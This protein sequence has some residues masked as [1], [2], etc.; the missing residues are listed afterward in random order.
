[1]SEDGGE[2]NEEEDGPDEAVETIGGGRPPAA[3]CWS[4]IKIFYQIFQ[5]AVKALVQQGLLGA[6]LINILSMGIEYHNQVS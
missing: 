6:I 5:R 2:Y 1:M 3:Q 4:F